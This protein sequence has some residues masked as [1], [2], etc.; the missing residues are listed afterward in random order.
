MSS[1]VLLVVIARPP[2]HLW[3]YFPHMAKTVDLTKCAHRIQGYTS[4][5]CPKIRIKMFAM[6]AARNE[7]R[8]QVGSVDRK[9]V[10][11][12]SESEPQFL[13]LCMDVYGVSSA[14]LGPIWRDGRDERTQEYRQLRH[15]VIEYSA[16]T[17]YH[18]GP[19]IVRHSG[20]NYITLWR[21]RSYSSTSISVSRRPMLNQPFCI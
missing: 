4:T 3:N 11:C 12:R 1:L 8:S 13:F 5:S 6:K 19:G 14:Q 17:T 2:L 20:P 15:P 7:V 10:S 16:R 9:P 18:N 21:D